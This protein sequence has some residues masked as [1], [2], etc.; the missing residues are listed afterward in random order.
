MNVQGDRQTQ[1]A[2]QRQGIWR[3]FQSEDIARIE[4][5]EQ[6]CDA[7]LIVQSFEK[8]LYAPQMTECL[9]NHSFHR[10]VAA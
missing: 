8:R 1:L 7:A 2:E 10:D 5:R 3:E 4:A 6:L 9:R